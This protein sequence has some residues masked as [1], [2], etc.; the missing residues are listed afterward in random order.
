MF[1]FFLLTGRWFELRLRDRTAGALEALMNRLPVGVERQKVDGGFELVAV[2]RL[3]L[4]DVVRILPGQA[5]P[6][7]GVVISGRTSVDESLL[8]GESRPIART[9]GD[10]VIAGSH[11]LSAPVLVKVLRL[12]EQTRFAQI[13]QLMESAS[14]SRPQMARLA[15]Q[16]ARPFLVAVLLAAALACAY[17]WSTDPERAL[18]VAVAVL[19]VTCPCALSLATP[20]AMLSAAGALARRGVLVRRLDAFE[21][22][23]AT[24][25]LIF[26]KTGTLTRDAMVLG[27]FRVRDDSDADEVLAMAAAVAAHSLHPV[28]RALV[29]AFASKQHQQPWQVDEVTE[30]TGLGLTAR[31]KR[32]ASQQAAMVVRLGSAQ[33]CSLPAEASDRLQVYLADESGWLASFDLQEDVRAD[34]P[35]TVCQLSQLGVDVQLLSGD[36]GAAVQRVAERVGIHAFSGQCSPADKLK[37]VQ[38]MQGQGRKVA[39]VGDGLNDGPVLAG[40]DAS[41]AFGSAVPLAQAKADFIVPEQRLTDVAWAITLARSTL[42]VVRQNLWWAAGYNAVSVPLAIVGWMPAWLAGIGMACSSLLV[43]FNAFRLARAKPI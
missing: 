17:W 34:A 31:V 22:L 11:N 27:A 23:A 2:R 10:D 25:V 5:F 40:A 43:V 6:A 21:T 15:D 29:R 20:A 37:R 33:H 19:V 36:A 12:G 41:F 3:Q 30:Q 4:D 18:M 16:V 42:K 9:A 38:Q 13:V 26:D 7:D 8:T 24:D 35:E 32:M 28:S 39:M 14:T 1:V